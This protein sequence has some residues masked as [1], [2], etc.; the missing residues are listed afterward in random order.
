MV[1]G[2]GGSAGS[3]AARRHS[4]SRDCAA[5]PGAKIRRDEGGDAEAEGAEADDREPGGVTHDISPV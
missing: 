2:S 1:F 5:A 4:G 3:A